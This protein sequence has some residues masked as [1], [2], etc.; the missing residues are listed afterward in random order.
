MSSEPFWMTPRKIILEDGM[1]IILR[2]SQTNDLEHTWRMFSSLSEETLQY[3]PDP[4]TRE[5]VES[6]FSDID[7]SKDLPILGIVYK[8][9]GYKVVSSASLHFQTGIYSHKVGFG[10]TVHDDYQ[11]KGFGQILTKYMLEIAKECGAK[12]VVLNVVAHNFRAIHVYE[13]M[14]FEREG[15]RKK[16]YWNPI[17]KRYGDTIHMGLILS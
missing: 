8:N 9:S 11:N 1:E 2:P 7:Y 12:K 4:I 15:Y 10:I 16:D 13:K 14:G 3:L 17:L 5:R 6:W